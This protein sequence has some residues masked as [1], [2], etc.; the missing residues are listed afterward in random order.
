MI[1]RTWLCLM[2]FSFSTGA[3]MVS[4]REQ[5]VLIDEFNEA[6]EALEEG[7]LEKVQ[8]LIRQYPGI[9]LASDDD[10]NTLLHKASFLGHKDLVLL[11]LQLGA[12]VNCTNI[13]GN[14]PLHKAG[15]TGNTE[16]AQLLLAAGADT[17]AVNGYGL[18]PLHCAA[19]NG[20]VALC[21]MLIQ[22]PKVISSLRDADSAIKRVVTG[23]CCMKYYAKLPRELIF[24][25]F[26][27]DNELINDF[28]IML[29]LDSYNP[30]TRKPTTCITNTT[31]WRLLIKA[32]SDEATDDIV[33]VPGDKV[34]LD[35]PPE[36]LTSLEASVYGNSWQMTQWRALDL[37]KGLHEKAEQEPDT[38]IEVI[39]D[40]GEGT[41]RQ[42]TRPFRVAYHAFGVAEYA[43][44]T[45]VPKSR[46][47][48][49]AFP[50]AKY[51]LSKEASQELE[52]RYLFKLPLEY[53]PEMAQRAYTRL[54]RL[55]EREKYIHSSHTAF[56]DHMLK[57]L[58]IAYRRLKS[59]KHLLS[60]DLLD[61]KVAPKPFT[62]KHTALAWLTD[63]FFKRRMLTFDA[64]T[65]FFREFCIEQQAAYMLAEDNEGRIAYEIAL[66]DHEE[67]AELLHPDR[68]EEH[69]GATLRSQ[70]ESCLYL[71]ARRQFEHQPDESLTALALRGLGLE[72]PV[73]ALNRKRIKLHYK[74]LQLQ[75]NAWSGLPRDVQFLLKAG[76]YIT[77]APIVGAG[78]VIA[79]VGEAETKKEALGRA[80]A[81][82]LVVPVAMVASIP[83][84]LF[85]LGLTEAMS[86]M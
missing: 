16:I 69:F 77:I 86:D 70:L 61:M 26:T 1:Y 54:R 13:F 59:E 15:H 62:K 83:I 51:K 11:L 5:K 40:G 56:V 84:A 78:I 8:Q 64:I 6:S 65:Y 32:V 3:M 57:I 19:E 53:S 31:A 37:C 22:M 43:P 42:F 50:C 80:A 17:H 85:W 24:M 63:R 75:Q 73:T 38:D 60:V 36:E 82:P 35:V 74:L 49:D 30:A 44:V 66:A 81:L 68:Y 4:P 29:L 72:G 45:L 33:L 39:I 25:I 23:L 71:K 47:L 27:I 41:F 34:V 52:V 12:S 48:L 2:L 55:W 7:K 9:I 46:V 28:A 18:T 20:S 79:R 76:K 67:L 14:T 21:K 58:D 10:Q